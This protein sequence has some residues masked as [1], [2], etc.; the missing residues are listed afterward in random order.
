MAYGAVLVAITLLL[1]RAV[2]QSIS[3]SQTAYSASFSEEQ[4]VGSFVLQLQATGFDSNSNA[5]LG[6]FTLAGSDAQ[7]FSL[8][9][10]FQD[11]IQTT[12]VDINSAAVFDWD[13]ANAQREFSFTA[14]FT[15]PGSSRDIPVT[16]Q[17]TDVNDNTPKFPRDVFFVQIPELQQAGMQILNVS[18]LDPDQILFDT[19]SVLIDPVN[20]VFETEVIP[21]VTNGLIFYSVVSGNELGHFILSSDS[22]ILSVTPGA[23]LDVDQI[24]LYNLTILAVDG[25]GRN[26]SAEVY[27]TIVDSNDNAPT[28]VF[29]R[30]IDVAISEDTDLGY[31]ILEGINATDADS[32]VNAV[33]QFLIISGDS[34]GNFG[35]DRDTGRINVSRPLDREVQ[36][37]YNLTVAARD[38]G[39]PALQDTIFV[40]VRLLDVND[41]A[42]RFTQNSYTISIAENAGLDRTVARVSAEDLDEGVNGTISYSLNGGLGRFYVN[43]VTGDILTNASLDREE[44]SSY[45]LVLVAVDNPQNLSNQL[46]SQVNVTVLIEDVNDNPPIFERS[47]YTVEV[48]DNITRRVPIIQL[49]AV[50]EDSGSNQQVT[51]A[52]LREDP[53]YPIAFRI[54]SGTGE[55]FRNRRL[56]YQNQSRFIYIIEARDNAQR[57]SFSA[58]VELTIILHDVNVNAPV[59]NPLFYNNT[60][61]EDEPIGTVVAT[62]SATDGDDGPI[63]QVRYRIVSEFDKA[64]AFTVNET[65]GEIRVASRLDFDTRSMI[66]FVVEAYDGGFPEPFTDYANVTIELT[67]QNDEAPIIVLP[68]GFQLTVPENVPPEVDIAVLRDYTVDPDIGQTGD[69]TF[70]LLAI[71]D[72]YSENASFSLNETTGLLTSL[73]TFDR[74]EQPNGINI[75][76]TTVDFEGL[77]RDMNLTVTI[78]DMNDRSP[79]FTSS[80]EVTVYEFLPAGTEVLRNFEATDE[81]IGS[82]ADLRYF[83]PSSSDRELFTIEPTTGT[84]F[85]AAVLNKT[86]QDTYNVTVLVMDQGIQPLFG[87]GTIIVTVL[88]SNDMIPVFSMPVYK[89]FLEENSISDSFVAEVNATD[90]DIGTNSEIRYYISFDN[91]TNGRFR[92]D[93]VSGVIYTTDMFDRELESMINLTVV[94]VDSGLVPHPLTGSA[95][96]I[97]VIEDINDHTPVFFESFYNATVTEN[98]EVNS[99][100]VV[101]RAQ[102][103]DATPPNNIISY[104]LRG[105]RS[106]SLGVN[107]VSGEI[108]IAGEVDWEEGMEFTIDIVAT[109]RNGLNGSLTASVPLIVTIIDANDNSPIF[110][111]SSLNLTIEENLSPLN[112]SISVGFVEADDSDS[113]GN[114]SDITYSII[115]DFANG[116][117]TLDTRSGEVLFVRGTLNRERRQFYELEIRATD[118]GMPRLYTDATLIISVADA[119]DFDPVFVQ[120]VFSGSV[121]ERAAAGTPVLTVNATD[122]DEGSNA[123]LRYRFD[124]YSGVEFTMD[125]IT[126]VVSVGGVLDYEDESKRL[127]TLA[128]VVNDLGHPPRIARTVVTIMV[129]DSNDLYPQFTEPQ[130][131]AIVREN[132]ANGTVVQRVMAADNDTIRENKAI[133]YSLLSSPGSENFGIDNT[134]GVVYTRTSLDREQFSTYNLTIVASNSLS[135]YP[136]STPVQLIIDVTDINDMHPTLPLTVNVD[137]FENETVGSIVYTLNAT[138]ADEA[139]N[140]TIAYSFI[141]PSGYFG[142][143]RSTGAITLTR[144]IDKEGM[145]DMFILPIQ[146]TDFGSPPLNNYTN[147]LIR[148]IDSNDSPPEFAATQYSVSVSSRLAVGVTFLRLIVQDK[149]EG[150]NAEVTTTIMAGNEQG[151][152]GISNSGEL[153]LLGSLM[154]FSGMM[155]SLTVQASDGRFNTDATVNIQVYGTS[156]SLPIFQS[157]SYSTVLSEQASMGTTVFD[158]SSETNNADTFS[159]NSTFLSIDNSGNLVLTNSTFLD[160]EAQ[161]VHQVTISILQSST[162]LTAQEVLT[163]MVTDENEYPPAFIAGL[164]LVW[165]PET[166]PVDDVVFTAIATDRDGTDANTFIQYDLDLTPDAAARSKFTIDRNTGEVRLAS[167]LVG[168]ELFNLTIRAT[169][170]QSSQPLVSTSILQITVLDGNSFTP[171]LSQRTETFFLHEDVSN[172]LNIVNISAT[173]MDSGSSGSLTFGLHGNH[174]YIDF[175]I[176]TFTGALYINEPLDYE[177]S[178]SYTLDVIASDG[179]NPTRS[180]TA[181]VLVEIIDLNDNSPVWQQSIYSLTLL[182]STSIGTNVIQVLATDRDSI[183]RSMDANNNIV[184]TGRNGY[185]EYSISQGDPSNYF[186]I[187][188]D[189]GTVTVASSLDREA[190]SSLN[191]TLNATDG[192]GLFANA[193]LYVEIVDVNDIVPRFLQD[194]YT[195]ELTEDAMEGT[196]VA[197]IAAEDSDLRRNSELRYLFFDDPSVSLDD[198]TFT[199]SINDTT[200]QISLEQMI[201]R[202]SIQQYVLNVIAVDMGAMP[203]TGSTQV[204]VRLLDINEFPPSFTE[205]SFYGEIIENSPP[206]TSILQINATDPDFGENATILY[207]ISSGD[208]AAFSINSITGIISVNGPIDYENRSSYELVVMATDAAAE[209]SV[210]LT[211]SVNVTIAVLDDNDNKPIFIGLP[212]VASI[213][214]YSIPGDYILNVSVI[215]LDSGSNSDL[216]YSLAFPYERTSNNFQIDSSTGSITLANSADLDRETI[217]SYN[218]TVIVTDRGSSPLSSTAMVV[219]NLQDENDNT[220]QFIHPYFEGK[221]LE[222]LQPNFIVANVSAEDADVGS[223][224]DLSYVINKIVPGNGSCSV[225]GQVDET[226]CNILLDSN[227]SLTGTLFQIDSISGALSTSSALDRESIGSFLIEVTVEDNG[228]PQPR[229]NTTFVLVELIDDNDQVPRFSQAVYYANISEHAQSGVMVIQV[230]AM[231]LDDGSNAEI[232]FTMSGSNKF[233][234]NT[235]SGEII[236]MANDFDREME[237]SYTLTVTASDGGMP[238]LSSTA[239]VVVTI[240]DENDSPPNFSELVFTTSIPEN[241]PV[242]AFVFQLNAS[243]ADIGSN[244]EITFTIISFDPAPHFE[245]DGSTGQLYTTQPL[246][247]ERFSSYSLVISAE[248]GGSPSLSTSAQVEVTVTDVNDFAPAFIGIPYTLTQEEN[249]L[250]SQ[251]ILR[252]VSFDLDVGSNRDSFYSI[253]DVLPP[254]NGTFEIGQRSGDLVLLRSLDAEESLSYNVTIVAD[255]GNSTPLQSSETVIIINVV[256]LN[257][258][259]P[260]FQQQDY[261]IPVLESSPVGSVVTE[262]TAFDGDATLQNSQLSFEITGGRNRS[263]FNITSPRSGCG[264]S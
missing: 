73:R 47:S 180:S 76:V 218:F 255:N 167:S 141:Q 33:I 12:L 52:I 23:S 169:N 164:F 2:C 81:D 171:V 69:F 24:S 211:S 139:E 94:A 37:T 41:F 197:T 147:V 20:N 109:D 228:Q 227:S 82:N 242:R 172:G 233:T 178:S 150:R 43:S 263:L 238:S 105:N 246:N 122:N 192:G 213:S 186:S 241:G 201:D 234:I 118:N 32:G 93:E 50:D 137:V 131:S 100:I 103:A 99:T 252:V 63:G 250:P 161:P 86:I 77:T 163:L 200:G 140:G 128:V 129:T 153:S 56:S 3:V 17:I 215:D 245:I 15:I 108:F 59:F 264:L 229:S 60:I 106:D 121:P 70:Q 110:V 194:P 152:F 257:D 239:T 174:H 22:A 243:D 68:N 136:L 181:V 16:V 209:P 97:V 254:V 34:A 5:I 256:D 88:D 220:P 112:G 104:S 207:S 253:V 80:A 45:S 204:Q 38:G 214:E 92:L 130:Y 185:V 117:F 95:T 21:V 75:T 230:E 58:P 251:P 179:G 142:L 224:A 25:G 182:E 231:D 168:D 195:I 46:S 29:P 225:V 226:E 71:Y 202:E 62:V 135:P 84:L 4:P 125:A 36:A 40:V 79:F 249:D 206:M 98:M 115:M 258:N 124:G 190:Y 44:R 53:T 260:M 244:S 55:I 10:S 247:R 11:Q 132:L 31:V 187:D 189:T 87:Y 138:D 133:F 7:Y 198:P 90:G 101:A 157:S 149:D 111:P 154:S 9:N 74:E 119:N 148:V 42:P 165:L 203:L 107:P 175:R 155:F 51:Y 116:K 223:N 193:Y 237:D 144:N 14:T 205:S 166:T 91:S 57:P 162:Q 39:T 170:T 8:G 64:G 176:D 191:L 13:Q 89:A 78:R 232:T 212:Y 262:V 35:I 248:D 26:S 151:L 158:F 146:M 65:S 177:R 184:I 159:V 173:D 72:D 27:I 113:F 208:T 85:T 48:L 222:N 217:P 66:H 127:F 259:T 49:R 221:V 240:L 126:G 18:A 1:N 30:G 134:S 183:G 123:E 219:V 196:L 102:D 19:R 143:N 61:R 6:Q 120:D 199:F 235:V 96:V 145:E 114:N 160:F 54:D 261:A 156:N 210:R 28:I 67:G 83:L 216:I 236:T 188:P